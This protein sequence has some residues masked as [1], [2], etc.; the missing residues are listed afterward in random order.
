MAT[1]LAMW[2]V[3]FWSSREIS[4]RICRLDFGSAVAQLSSLEGIAC[5]SKIS[6]SRDK[7]SIMADAYRLV[8]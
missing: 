6:M 2:S 1:Q 3:N 8:D 4:T 7:I 5:A